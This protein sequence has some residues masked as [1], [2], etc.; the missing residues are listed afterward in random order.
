MAKTPTFRTDDRSRETARRIRDR[1]WRMLERIADRNPLYI[2][3]WNKN[4][5]HEEPYPNDLMVCDLID[6]MEMAHWLK[7][8]PGWVTVGEWSD[9]RY[10]APVR[11]T[12]SGRA[13]LANREKYDMEP[14]EAGL[15]EPGWQAIPTPG[16][17]CESEER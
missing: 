14:V 12:D 5:R 9:D 7:A 13:A 15:V 3:W 1:Q 6:G 11:I 4:R 10:A 2:C 8:H 16:G 17:P